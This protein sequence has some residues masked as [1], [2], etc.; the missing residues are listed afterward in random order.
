MRLTLLLFLVS[1]C[2]LDA[3]SY[4][5]RINRRV[6]IGD[7]TQVHQ[8]ILRD[9]S[10]LRGTV[11][12]IRRDSLFIRV[13][14]VPELIG[15]PTYQMRHLGIL[16]PAGLLTI[17]DGSSD[18]LPQLDDLTFVRT[19]LPFA[20]RRR[21]KTVML[22][23]NTLDFNLN[24][25]LQLSV[26]MGGPIGLILGQR[27]RTSLT[28]YLH[29]GLSNELL[30]IPFLGLTE[31]GFPAVGDATALLTVGSSYQFLNLGYGLFYMTGDGAD[32]SINYRLGAGVRISRKTHLYGEMVGVFGQEDEFTLLPSLNLATTSRRH[33][34]TLGLMSVFIEA[35]FNSAVPIP[36]LSY[37][38]YF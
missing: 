1:L 20:Y 7:S 28:P 24:R 18:P 13:A 37:A 26:G 2:G 29:V 14:T 12:E 32:P 34:W 36:Y 15:I 9:Y 25:H 27:Y 10:R 11:T 22:L 3:Q 6:V 23:Y 35:Q 21:F 30:I 16:E 8:L 5:E 33:R 4:T 19:A 38:V 17:A 31:S